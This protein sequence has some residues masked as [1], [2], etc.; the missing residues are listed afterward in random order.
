M[1]SLACSASLAVG[2]AQ[3]CSSHLLSSDVPVV[4]HVCIYIHMF[5]DGP[6]VVYVPFP[7][8]AQALCSLGSSRC[9][10]RLKRDAIDCASGLSRPNQTFHVA[11]WHLYIYIYVYT[12]IYI[13]IYMGVLVCAYIYIYV[14]MY[15]YICSNTRSSFGVCVH[16]TKLA[17]VRPVG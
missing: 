12:C 16:N 13:Y 11:A 14:S 9:L 8:R 5:R 1:S 7:L 3:D 15:I 17:P 6:A 2:Q 10:P 4:V